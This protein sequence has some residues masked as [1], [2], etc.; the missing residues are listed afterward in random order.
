MAHKKSKY[1]PDTQETCIQ[2]DIQERMHQIL[3]RGG[4]NFFNVATGWYDGFINPLTGKMETGDRTTREYNRDYYNGSSMPGNFDE[5][6][7]SQPKML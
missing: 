5:F 6:I 3:T 2:T 7:I 4:D 1:D